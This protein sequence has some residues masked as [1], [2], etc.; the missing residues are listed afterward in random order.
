MSLL[1]SKSERA[2]AKTFKLSPRLSVTFTVGP[3]KVIREW[4]PEEPDKLTATELRL[5]RKACAEMTE[6]WV[7]MLESERA[8]DQT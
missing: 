5:Y 1:K 7:E 3:A 6:R 4:N 2:V 8:D